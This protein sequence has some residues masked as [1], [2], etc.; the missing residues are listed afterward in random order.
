M[1]RTR[2]T[3]VARHFPSFSRLREPRITF[4]VSIRGRLIFPANMYKSVHCRMNE[5]SAVQNE[6]LVGCATA[7]K[8]RRKRRRDGP[9]SQVLMEIE[10]EW[11]CRPTLLSLLVSGEKDH[12]ILY[13]T[14]VSYIQHI[15]RCQVG[16]K[17][18]PLWFRFAVSRK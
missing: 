11:Q 2:Q 7:K 15:A 3:Y 4:S 18:F 12:L 1:R 6:L 17:T 16:S 5:A 13:P 14:K 9:K 10:T 8:R